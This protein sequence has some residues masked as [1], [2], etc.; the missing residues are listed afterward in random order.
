MNEGVL[1][2]LSSASKSCTDD[3]SAC[4]S[5]SLSLYFRSRWGGVWVVM[6]VSAFFSNFGFPARFTSVAYVSASSLLF[7]FASAH[8]WME[9]EVEG[10][11]GSSSCSRDR[12]K[13]G[14]LHLKT[15]MSVSLS[16][17][18]WAIESLFE[19]GPLFFSFLLLLLSLFIFLFW[20]A[21]RTFSTFDGRI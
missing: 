1:L 2:S 5:L 10:G 11:R 16:L 18:F 4:T 6:R 15:P 20:H 8:Q 7:L 17:C 19:Q 9:L 14:G 12:V 13:L 21:S 3:I